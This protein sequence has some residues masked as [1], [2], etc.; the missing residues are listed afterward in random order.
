[1]APARSWPRTSAWAAGDIPEVN[2]VKTAGLHASHGDRFR[3]VSLEK[4]WRKTKPLFKPP[5]GQ[6]TSSGRIWYLLRDINILENVLKE[7]VKK[8]R[9]NKL[10]IIIHQLELVYHLQNELVNLG[11]SREYT[12]HL[13][14]P[15]CARL[16]NDSRQRGRYAFNSHT[17]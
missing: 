6:E 13:G 14:Y 11:K 8:G 15:L 4:K 1:M 3:L 7:V 17:G 2:Q 5:T 10:I 16:R 9:A 12:V